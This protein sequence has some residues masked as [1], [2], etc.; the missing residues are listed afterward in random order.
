[1]FDQCGT[2]VGGVLGPSPQI[3]LK[4]GGRNCRVVEE[5]PG[6]S[7]P[8]SGYFGSCQSH[9]SPAQWALCLGS[10]L[11]VGPGKVLGQGQDRAVG[12]RGLWSQV[13]DPLASL[14]GMGP[15]TRRG[16]TVSWLPL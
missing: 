12:G 8:H 9:D 15:A 11:P 16:R 2:E 5:V 1:M 4:E 13:P 6:V 14:A 7:L 10:F 3:K